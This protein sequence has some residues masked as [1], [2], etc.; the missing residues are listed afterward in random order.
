[1]ISYWPRQTKR[2]LQISRVYP[3][4]PDE[5]HLVTGEGRHSWR[6]AATGSWKELSS[7]WSNHA[8]EKGQCSCISKHLSPSKCVHSHFKVSDKDNINLRCDLKAVI[9][10]THWTLH[11]ESRCGEQQQLRVLSV[12]STSRRSCCGIWICAQIKLLLIFS[13]KDTT[14]SSWHNRFKNT[15]TRN[16]QE[17][18]L[19]GTYHVIFE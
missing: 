4:P 19:K 10:A 9:C 14:W 11:V 15:S 6:R 2:S 3:S 12:T 5:N 1:M 18:T 16:K 13:L 8:A 7:T 17:N